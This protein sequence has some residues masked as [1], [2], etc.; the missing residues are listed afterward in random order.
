MRTRIHVLL[1]SLFSITILTAQQPKKPT[2]SEIYESIKKLNF[3]G[4]VLYVAAHPDDEN[5][6]L[7]SYMSN[8]IKARTAYLSLTRGDGGQNLIGPEIRELLGVIRTQELLAARR[9]DGGEQRFTRANDFGY[10]KHPDETFDIWNKENVLSDVVLAIRQFQPDVIINRFNHRT[11]GTTHGHHTGSAMLSV[12]AFDL[13]GDKNA[14]PSQLSQVDTWQP[15]RLFFNTSWWFYG[16]RENFEKA[17]K[18]N[19]LELDTGVYFPSSGVSN[20]EIAALSR[21]QHKSQGFGSTGSRGSQLE[22]I[23]LIK[24]DLPLDKSNVFDGI[25]TSWDR[26]EGGKVIGDILTAVQNDYDFQNPSASIPELIRAYSLIQNLNNNHWKTIK[27]EDIKHIIAACA[28]LYLEATA[29]TNHATAGSNIEVT[30]EAIN[31]S[32]SNIILKSIVNPNGMAISKDISLANNTDFDFKETLAINA[33]QDVST[34]YWLTKKGTLGM[35][36]VDDAE[37]IGLPET[38]RTLNMIFN[39]NIETIDIPFT[40][41]IVF[42]S[43]DPVK[44]EVYKPFEII[45][46]VSARISEQVIIMDNDNPRTIE[47]IVTA[48]TDNIEGYVELKHPEQWRV[49]P[50][51]EQINITNK[52]QEQRIIFTITPPKQQNEG[53]IMPVVHVGNQRYTKELIE[54][55]YDHIP[56]QTVLLPSESKIVRLD[57]KKKGQHIAYIEGAGDVVPESLRHIGY[58][59]VILKPEDISAEHLK[60]FDAVVVGIRAYNTVEELKFKQ[61]LLFDYV[62]QGGNM[63]VQY[64]T[65]RRLKVDQLAP[66]DLKLSRDRV[67]DEFAEV[68][69]LAADHEVLNRPNKITTADFDG[70]TQERGLYFPNAW[71][72][73]FTAVLSMNDKDESPKAGS[74]LVAKYGKGYYVYTGLSFFREF[75]AGVSGAYRLFAN[76]LSLG[77]NEDSASQTPKN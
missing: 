58:T 53:Y 74:L 44:G 63:I 2:T 52:G 77:K 6:R 60:G 55:D 29:N 37:L 43:N 24:G 30:I 72:N 34:P 49:S 18:T 23:E 61:Q 62:N 19:L 8:E 70:W 39:L 46:E 33:N 75:P 56:F 65:N 64:N 27:T 7:I 69:L 5:T 76:M 51:T 66:F 73:E 42:K 41:P 57:I 13:V 3:L 68:R 38:P 32:N 45:P 40:R 35:Y 25:D 22:Y 16:S 59:V 54:I 20:P 9:T 1:L 71:S 48:G 11:P 10:S 67:T 4:S 12:E 26:V 17:D 50:K 36:K 15:Q 14:Y 28:G 21:S 47:V 31:R